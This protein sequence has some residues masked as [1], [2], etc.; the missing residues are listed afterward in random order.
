[1]TS[2][3]D[4]RFPVALAATMAVRLDRFGRDGVN[5][6]F[7]ESSTAVGIRRGHLRKSGGGPF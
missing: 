4:R 3:G 7:C 5:F 1:M 6:E 2:Q